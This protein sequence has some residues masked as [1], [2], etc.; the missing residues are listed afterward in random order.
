MS[1]LRTAGRR[2]FL[3]LAS[4]QLACALLVMLGIL[5]WLG[6]LE[7]VHSGLFEVQRKYFESFV[8]M[9]DAGPVSIPLPG[10]NLVLSL[11]AVNLV[12]GGFVRIR[13]S[14]ET[15]GI[16]V[17]HAGIVLL[18]VAGFVKH[19][20]SQDGR[21][22]LRE[23]ESAA[24]FESDVAWELVVR[25]A[26]ADGSARE[27][28]VPF[29]DLERERVDAPAEVAADGLPFAIEVRAALANCRPAANGTGVQLASEPRDREVARNI[30]GVEFAIASGHG[31][32]PLACLVWGAQSA[33]FAATVDRRRF[34]FDLR[35]ER[36][37]LPFTLTLADFRKEDHPRSNMPRSFESDVVVDGE[38]KVT[39]SM[40]EPLR[41]DGLVVYQAS[42]GPQGAGPGA[43]L[44]S[45]FAVVRNPADSLPLVA[46]IVIA[47]GL[48]HHFTRKLAR[49][50]RLQ[51]AAHGAVA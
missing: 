32:P 35:R 19:H 8:L 49:H 26:L 4:M 11:L 37:A 2:A 18:L 16:L 36:H 43:V 50:V 51:R 44:F 42:W 33:P 38:R 22:T 17:T 24:W 27:H 40:N 14:R 5:T 13:K 47:L 48:M 10:A 41:A 45:T 9:H 21:V 7:Q 25:E 46:C 6:T 23:G 30:P 31:T 29:A 28:V 34:E 20:A 3:V 1:P 39:I 15:I 12:L